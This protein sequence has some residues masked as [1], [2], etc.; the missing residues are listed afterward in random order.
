[1]TGWCWKHDVRVL[2]SRPVMPKNPPGTLDRYIMDETVEF[3]EI[4][5]S[6]SKTLGKKLEI[7]LAR[8]RNFNK[9]SS[10]P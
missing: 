6:K 7:H 5:G 3:Q 8:E 4:T 9:S 10:I 1:M 2:G